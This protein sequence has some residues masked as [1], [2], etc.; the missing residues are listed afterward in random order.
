MVEPKYHNGI[1]YDTV[2]KTNK[3]IEIIL[4]LLE[5]NISPRAYYLH[6]LTGGR[7]WSVEHGRETKTVYIQDEQIATFLALHLT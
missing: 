3:P 4:L 6:N 5:K 2:I 1:M 7:G